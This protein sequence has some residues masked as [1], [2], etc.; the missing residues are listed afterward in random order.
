MAKFNYLKKNN[1]FN[2]LHGALG[3][4]LAPHWT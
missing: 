4:Y 1:I 3:S 2:D